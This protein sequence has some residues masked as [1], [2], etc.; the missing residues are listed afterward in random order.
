MW[1]AKE[2]QRPQKGWWA[3]GVYINQCRRC[4]DYFIGDKRSGIC[5]D[6]AYNPNPKPKGIQVITTKTNHDSF[7]DALRAAKAGDVITLE[8]GREYTTRGAWAFPDR[9]FISVP[10]GVTIIATG[11][12]ITL[13]DPVTSTHGKERPDRDL[14]LLWCGEEV[15]IEGGTWDAGGVIDN[16]GWF[17]GG[18]RFHG[19]FEIRNAKIMGL[20]G[21]R[22]SGTPV[23]E[24]ESFAISSKG[25]TAG[26]IVERVRVNLCK[27][28]H[29]D[30]YVSGI[31]VGST[32]KQKSSKPSIVRECH[33]D[34]GQHGQF[35]YACNHDT[36]F[37]NCYGIASRGFYNDTG[38]TVAQLD[39]C[40]LI[41]SY[42]GISLVGS[43]TI[44]TE[45]T[46][47]AYECRVTAPRLVEWF[48]QDPI[49]SGSVILS[50]G[51]FKGEYATAIKG[52]HGGIIL[53]QVRLP[54]DA[55]HALG[56]GS[57]PPV[58]FAEI[59]ANE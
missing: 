24:V 28:G 16:P 11:A 32:G 22:K 19:R 21:S 5:A 45:R 10:S 30:D 9:G 52:S 37:A 59:A 44:V 33:V 8:P 35:A 43:K 31:F 12:T 34:L 58:V 49:M 13:K 56:P 1:A 26:S 15:V 27:T 7:D 29:P 42:A 47:V 50:G 46:V 38:D 51:W 53:D 54:T 25:Q 36:R 23:G 48:E 6:C 14:Q 41:G 40:D 20:S 55:E 3:P 39:G 57:T 18:L 2:D 4:S 17:C